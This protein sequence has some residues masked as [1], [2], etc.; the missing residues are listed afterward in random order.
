PEVRED[1]PP[2]PPTDEP[3]PPVEE[4]IADFT[5]ETIVAE[6]PGAWTSAV[7]NG[8]SSD[9]PIGG[10]T[11]VTTG[12]RREGGQEGVVG[13]TGQGAVEQVVAV[14]DLR[15]LPVPPDDSRLRAALERRYP[16]RLRGLSIE[17]RAVVR[18]TI[19]ANGDL[20]RITVRSTT[21]PEFGAA[22]IEALRDVGRWGP[23]MGPEG[24]PV[25]TAFS[26]N[27]DFSLSF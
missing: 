2:P 6:G 25:S 16:A 19:R 14:R 9:G 12:R 27:C 18:V 1:T 20:G 21:E 13:G 26:F 8:E 11:G 22:C 4:Q 23:A 7:G 5:G 10:P 3:P 17:G 24:T 15:E